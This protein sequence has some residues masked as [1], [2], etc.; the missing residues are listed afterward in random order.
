M[1]LCEAKVVQMWLSVDPLADSMR[2]YSPYS[3]AFD[4][5]IRFID[6]D[7]RRPDDPPGW[8]QKAWSAFVGLSTGTSG[9][10]SGYERSMGQQ[11]QSINKALGT[12]NDV[13]AIGDAAKPFAKEVAVRAAEATGDGLEI[14]GTVVSGVGYAAAPFTEGAS[15]S[16]VPIGAGLQETGSFINGTIK[17]GRG[18]Y[19][20]AAYSL[21]SGL[22]FGGVGKTL[23]KAK[24]A[25]TIT[26]TDWG[27]TSFFNDA[28][29]K[30]SDFFYDES[31]NK[32]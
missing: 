31:K 4:N 7:G 23:D 6:P 30:V 28:W 11:T 14:S 13:R 2:R 32:K 25:K 22:I 18:Q 3:Y 5:P 17:I 21:G 27:I 15:L 20:D 19:T 24:E 16:L 10:T 26:R 8:F 1:P 9:N 29:S 12:A